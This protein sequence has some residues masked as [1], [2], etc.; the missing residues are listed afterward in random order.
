MAL[1]I[2]LSYTAKSQQIIYDLKQEW[3]T[4]DEQVKG[5]LPTE[6]S[7]QGHHSISF[8]IPENK[9]DNFFLQ[10][11]V[12]RAAYLFCSDVLV[13]PLTAG[14]NLIRIDQLKKVCGPGHLF[15]TVYSGESIMDLNTYVVSAATPVIEN[16]TLTPLRS[17]GYMNAFIIINILLLSSFV[18]VRFSYPDVS[19]QY[20]FLG[21]II[22]FRTI[23]ELIY[24]IGPF[25]VPNIWMI[26]WISA[27]GGVCVISFVHAN[28]LLALAGLLNKL[29]ESFVGYILRWLGVSLALFILFFL[30]YLIVNLFSYVFAFKTGNHHFAGHLRLS[31]LIVVIVFIM[32]L[33][34]ELSVGHPYL[35]LL[36]TVTILLSVLRIFILFFKLSSQSTSTVIHLILYLCATEFIPLILVFNLAVG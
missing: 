35:S 25:S 8:G 17:H 3:V 23:D 12:K 16:N 31:F 27:V 9:Y 6:L 20:L 30:K 5:F 28:G 33:G 36:T 22:S 19:R 21:R 4:Y 11:H 1:L 2:C 10:I 18:I 14:N 32:S 24:K 13:Q 26:V 15:L 7:G 29:P 34:N